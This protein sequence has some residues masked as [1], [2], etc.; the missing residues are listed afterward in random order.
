MAA[1]SIKVI[2]KIPASAEAVWS[3]FSNYANL[4]QITLPQ[5]HFRVISQ[6]HGDHI[7]PGQ[8]IEYKLRVLG[9]PV[10]WMTEIT[11][12]KEN[13]FFVDEQRRGP[14]QMWHHQ[15]FFMPIPGGILMTD[16]VHYRNPAGFMGVIAD[17]IYVK[18]K[19]QEIFDYRFRN[20]EEV[21][22]KWQ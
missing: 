15:H 21:F 22:G 2:Q 14:Y 10:Y 6:H 9:M 1:S 4:Q 19:L 17:K 13:D 18:R 16:I 8:I 11:H 5:M 20:V 3:F 7:Y 12:V